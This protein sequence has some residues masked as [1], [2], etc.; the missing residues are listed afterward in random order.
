MKL[1]ISVRRT[2]LFLLL[3]IAP[4]AHSQ[5]VTGSVSG[6]V[7]DAGGALVVGAAVTLTNDISKQTR[8]FRTGPSGEFEFVSI[9]P[10]SYSVKIVQPGFKTYQQTNVTISSQE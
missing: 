10:G 3:A 2:L 8:E 1:P 6:T 7:A 4:A 9:I 5:T